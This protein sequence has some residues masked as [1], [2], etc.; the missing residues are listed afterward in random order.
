[1]K[2]LSWLLMHHRAGLAL[3]VGIAL[4]G[5]ALAMQWLALGPLQA[6][7]EALQAQRQAPRDQKLDRLG[8]VLAQSESPGAQLAGFYG[9]FAKDERLSDR[10]AR[11]HEVARSLGLEM[12]RAEYRLISQ[13]DRRLDRYQMVLPLTGSYPVIRRFVTTVLRE[14]PTVS[15]EQVQFQRKDIADAAVEAQVSFTFHLPR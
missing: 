4:A 3:W 13:P 11:L 8:D 2:R 10:L 1:M 7:V 12:R 15:L 14:M 6:R 9:Y 5:V